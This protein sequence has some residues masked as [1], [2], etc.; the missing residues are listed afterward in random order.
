[1]TNRKAAGIVFLLACMAALL[2]VRSPGTGDVA[3][4]M[5][6]IENAKTYGIRAGYAANDSDYP[7]L[8]M[9][10]LVLVAKL[11]EFLGVSNFTG[12]K[13]SLYLSLLL[14][15]FAF[16]VWTKNLLA[17]SLLQLSLTL[18][19]MALGYV[20]IYF[21]PPLIFALRALQQAKW[22]PFTLLFILACLIKW[23]PLML[24][25]MLV[26]YL[27]G[28]DG[29]GG[30]KRVNLRRFL[31]Q[32]ILPVSLTGVV[33]LAVFG[34]DIIMALGQAG[35]HPVLSG[36][37]LNL[38]WIVTHGLHVFLPDKF[39]PLVD[40]RARAIETGD[41]RILFGPKLVFL[42]AY[43]STLYAFIR[44]E[45]SFANLLLF[46][47]IGYLCYFTLSAG[48]HE[49]HLFLPSILA[50]ALACM[51]KRYFPAAIFVLLLANL[52][53]LL[54]YGMSGTGLPF[55]RVVGG[56]DVALPVSILAVMFFCVLFRPVVAE[57]RSAVGSSRGWG[58]GH[59]SRPPAE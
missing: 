16:F 34:I 26:V 30:L 22:L 29:A 35:T 52:N 20:D 33:C 10:F 14:T 2:F 17:T 1:M 41:A 19:S 7:P 40:G 31:L 45:K 46:S 50:M 23:Q 43:F 37:A 9:L 12:F 44:V 8:S 58:E 38:S 53:L 54:F 13:V 56:V 25:P 28:M 4:W 3:F 36:N 6:W 5:R 27:T 51:D 47:T 21:A 18:N 15:S 48:V 39:G 32:I 24:V 49:N 11:S 42:L 57:L 59:A 55:P